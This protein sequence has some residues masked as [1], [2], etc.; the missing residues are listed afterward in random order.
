ML[1]GLGIRAE[2]SAVKVIYPEIH[3]LTDDYRREKGRQYGN[4]SIENSSEAEKL[5]HET[6]I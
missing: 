4:R 3:R 2:K 5:G 6:G 1:D